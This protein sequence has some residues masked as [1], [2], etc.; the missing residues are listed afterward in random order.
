MIRSLCFVAGG[1]SGHRGGVRARV[2][3]R[4]TMG[5]ILGLLLIAGSTTGCL[6]A[7]VAGRIADEAGQVRV[8]RARVAAAD[9]H[10]PLLD[11]VTIVVAAGAAVIVSVGSAAPLDARDDRLT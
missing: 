7:W 3:R 8:A 5:K 1:E 6:G 9:D 10:H 11:A 2:E 4:N